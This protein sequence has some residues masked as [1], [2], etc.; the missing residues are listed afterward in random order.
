MKNLHVRRIVFSLLMIL[1]V[2]ALIMFR[3]FPNGGAWLRLTFGA[4]CLIMFEAARD[5]AFRSRVRW[6]H[7]LALCLLAAA[8][9]FILWGLLLMLWP[10][11]RSLL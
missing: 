7:G 5:P 11:I 4:T 10:M 3:D 6:A 8:I 9:I 1:L 2:I